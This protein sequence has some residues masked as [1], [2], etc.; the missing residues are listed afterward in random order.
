MR[1]ALATDNLPTD[2]KIGGIGTYTVLVAEELAR[3]GADVHIFRWGSPTFYHSYKKNDV[4]YHICP[5]WVSIRSDSFFAGSLW[6]IGT[7]ICPSL[8]NGL[9]LRF[10]FKRIAQQGAFDLAEFPEY[11]ACAI[12]GI[13]HSGVKRTYIRLHSCSQILRYYSSGKVD[14]RVRAIDRLEAWTAIRAYG[15]TSPSKAALQAT[16]QFWKRT[17]SGV[18]IIPNPSGVPS[19]PH[20]LVPRESRSIVFSGRL[21]RRKGIHILAQAIPQV[22][23]A[24]PDA[25]FHIFG[26]DSRWNDGR[27]GSHLIKEALP[28][29]NILDRQVHLH[30]PVQ[31]ALLLEYVRRAT[32]VVSASLYENL[33]MAVLEALACGAPLVIS[34]IPPHREII[35]S[36][37]QGLL[38]PSEDAGAL[39]AQLTRVLKSEA[40]RERLSSGALKR[41]FAFHISSIVDQ[42]L[43]TWGLVPHSRAKVELRALRNV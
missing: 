37:D 1:I 41:S 31:R 10:F 28:H 23:R 20:V 22:L 12:A 13:G 14:K 8:E 6:R 42:L 24:V 15:I 9:A 33:P 2:F 3:R 11:G 19:D 32:A 18:R 7:R 26:F 21:E 39:A 27:L 40:L 25:E 35:C 29:A 16:Q 5:S 17:L 38:F 30:G 36:E 34:D 43:E 4:T